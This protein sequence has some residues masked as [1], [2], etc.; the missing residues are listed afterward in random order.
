MLIP[1]DPVPDLIVPTLAHGVFNLKSETPQNFS[2]I[3]FFRGLH[4][5]LCIKYLKEL[6]QL[7]LPS[8]R[9]IRRAVST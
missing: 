3:V 5:P 8:A 9:I 1:R 7:I 2:L 4:C 6:G